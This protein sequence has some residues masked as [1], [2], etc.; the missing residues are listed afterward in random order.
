MPSHVSQRVTVELPGSPAFTP[1]DCTERSRIL[2]GIKRE[3][4][5]RATSLLKQWLLRYL[6]SV[7]ETSAASTCFQAARRASTAC[8]VE[9]V[10]RIEINA[11]HRS[12]WQP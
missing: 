4:P 11:L 9:T 3:Q 1:V 8:C 12:H 5:I 7:L 6:A 2:E 10:E